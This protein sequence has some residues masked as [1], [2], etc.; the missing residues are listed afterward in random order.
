MAAEA[1]TSGGSSE[2]IPAV[3]HRAGREELEVVFLG[4]GAAIPAKYRNV[5]GIFVNLFS[6]GGIMLD[7]GALLFCIKTS[8]G[9]SR[10]SVTHVIASACAIYCGPPA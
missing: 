9:Q 5:S 7:C 10:P 6:R 2:S 1:S 4:T 8:V 3:V